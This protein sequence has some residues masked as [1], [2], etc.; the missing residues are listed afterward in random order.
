VP[1]LR[2]LGHLATPSTYLVAVKDT[3]VKHAN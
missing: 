1:L 3:V 2:F